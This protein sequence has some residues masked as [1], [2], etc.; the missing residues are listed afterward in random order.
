[1]VEEGDEMKL[2]NVRRALERRKK[3]LDERIEKA[4]AEGKN[5]TF[6]RSESAAIEVALRLVGERQTENREAME[7]AG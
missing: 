5:L 3:H 2:G 7:R 4:E 1:V 6:D